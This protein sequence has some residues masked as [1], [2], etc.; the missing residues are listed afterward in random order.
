MDILHM[1]NQPQQLQQCLAVLGRT[2]ALLLCGDATY[3][4]SGLPQLS[5]PV[6]VLAE[7]AQARAMVLPDPVRLVDYAG[8]VRL[9]VEYKQVLAW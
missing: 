9:C 4:V 2:D 1:L 3:A 8:F 5:A 6:Y 7:D